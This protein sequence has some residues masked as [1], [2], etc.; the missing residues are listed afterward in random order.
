MLS[1]FDDVRY[2]TRFTLYV[3]LLSFSNGT[4]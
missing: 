4:T 2:G 3:M 1:R